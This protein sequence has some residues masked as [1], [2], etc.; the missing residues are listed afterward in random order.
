MYPPKLSDVRAVRYD[1]ERGRITFASN[2][3]ENY[4]YK[5]VKPVET[6]EF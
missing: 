1:A 2:E 6:P 3:M 4:Q 5:I